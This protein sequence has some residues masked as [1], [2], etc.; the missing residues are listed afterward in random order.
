MT[1]YGLQKND[2]LRKRSEF[3]RLS[4]NGKKIADRYFVLILICNPAGSSRIGLTVSKR[5]GNAVTRNRIKRLVREHFRVNRNLLN[6]S[7]DM[8]VIARQAAA[9]L[10]TAQIF[11]SL[12]RLF[13][14]TREIAH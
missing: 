3:L 13:E 11:A 10:S 9:N 2:K 4:A 12:T 8:N 5:V 7:W 14:K 6:G 1:K